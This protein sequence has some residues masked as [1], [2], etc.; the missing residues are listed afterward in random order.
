MS[1]TDRDGKGNGERAGT[2]VSYFR[3]NPGSAVGTQGSDL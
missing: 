2:I 3:G 1:G